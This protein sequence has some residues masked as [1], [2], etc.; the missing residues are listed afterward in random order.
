MSLSEKDIRNNIHTIL[1]QVHAAATSAN[2]R[3]D[4]IKLVVV[5]KRQ[6]IE[7]I[8]KAAR[9]GIKIFGENYAEEIEPKKQALTE[10]PDLEWHMI[11]HIQSR[12]A[13]V[14]AE[15][16][17]YVHSIDSLNLA[18]RLNRILEENNAVLPVLLEMNVSS[19]ESKG[20]WPAWEAAQWEKLFPEIEQILQC[21]RLQVRGLMT[22]P[23]LFADPEMVRPYFS[24]LARLRDFLAARYATLDWKEL[25]MGTSA[26]FQ[27]GVQEGATFIR[28]GQA[29]LGP[30]PAKGAEA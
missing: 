4:E 16:F 11:G 17:D 19:E 1:D 2:R 6:P 30:R 22:M 12:K 14:V 7:R 24:R 10:F 13:R 25:S 3:P 15:N 27:I 23:P 8:E 9:A 5:S 20:G 26:D 21:P 29:I 28:I 18:V